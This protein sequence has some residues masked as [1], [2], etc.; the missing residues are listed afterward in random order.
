MMNDIIKQAMIDGNTVNLAYTVRAMMDVNR[1]LKQENGDNLELVNVVFG[2]DLTTLD[3]FAKV[4]EIL[5]YSAELLRVSRGCKPDALVNADKVLDS[6]SPSELLEL[7]KA[8][9]SAILAGL[10]REEQSNEIDLGLAEL[11]KKKNRQ[12]LK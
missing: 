3:S 5:N 9:M 11:E 2:D 4:V 1:V 12:K 6:T 8:C 7:K 10:G